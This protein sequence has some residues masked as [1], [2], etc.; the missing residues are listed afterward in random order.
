MGTYEFLPH[1]ADEKF[2]VK[3][4][5]LSDGFATSVLAFYEILLGKGYEVKS[6]T[7]KE[8]ALKANKIESLLY[9]FMNELVFLFDDAD[10]LLPNVEKLE[11]WKC[12][13]GFFHIDAVLSGDKKYDYDLVTEIKNMTYNEMEI[14]EEN[15]SV[16]ITAVLDI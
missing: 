7:R 3:A 8:I 9:D 15:D 10:L 2:V 11:I 5:S 1:T 4:D 6:N 14:K 16:E 12:D 13:Q